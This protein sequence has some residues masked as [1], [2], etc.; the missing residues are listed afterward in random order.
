MI[1]TA[2]QKRRVVLPKLVQPGDALDISVVGQRMILQVLQK[3]TAVPPVAEQA[4]QA[5]DP[6]TI[7]L[8]E[9][10]F[11]AMTDESPA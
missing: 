6:D 2:D 10:A 8:D 4:L 7:D 3:P 5:R 9:P 1:V 11:L